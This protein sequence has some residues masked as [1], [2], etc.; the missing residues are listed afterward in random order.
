MCMIHSP[1]RDV[2]LVLSIVSN[3]LIMYNFYVSFMFC[4]F[5]TVTI[6]YNPIVL[7]RSPSPSLSL[8]LFVPVRASL[9]RRGEPGKREENGKECVCV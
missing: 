7:A 4:C 6:I 9:S 1:H 2:L 5:V 3:Y 8:S